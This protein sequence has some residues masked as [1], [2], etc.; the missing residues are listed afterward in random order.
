MSGV[1][2]L[3]IRSGSDTAVTTTL[4]KSAAWAL[5]RVAGHR[6]GA[7]EATPRGVLADPA[8]RAA[9]ENSYEEEDPEPVAEA[10][11]GL[12]AA[13]DL[14][15]GELPG[16]ANLA[17]P[18]EDGDWYPADELLLPGSALAEVVA[19]DAPFGVV[20]AEF[21]GRHGADV[22][23]AAGVLSTFGLLRGEDV[24]T[25][26]VVAPYHPDPQAA[27][28][29]LAGDDPPTA[30][31]CFS[32]AVAFTMI[33]AA[34]RRGM[35]VPGDLSVVGFDD[36]PMARRVTPGLTTVAQDVDAKGRAA[37]RLLVDA[38]AARSGRTPVTPAVDVVLPTTLVVR[39]STAPPRR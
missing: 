7:V 20:D 3:P 29:V 27:D 13:A 16:L 31:L 12:V 18:G 1:R 28:Q 11:L 36:A 37:A 19:D 14:E 4:A 25:S 24:E 2:P 39:G 38:M 9:V 26:L 6:L 10:V 32:D 21:A 30:V 15:P 5:D 34:R 8:T 35:D 23:E 33:D 17:L 22:L